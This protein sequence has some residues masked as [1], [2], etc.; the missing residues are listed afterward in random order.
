MK[1]SVLSVGYPLAPA[2]P[3]AA[4]GSEQILTLLD[5]ALV[6]EG[7]DSVV[8]A[9]EGSRVRGRLLTTPVPP[10]TL[11]EPARQSARRA[12]ARNIERA[13]ATW[14]FD[15]IHMHSLDFH[16]YLPAAATPL[17]ATLHLPPDW[18]PS[19]IFDMDRPDTW[20]QCVSRTQQENC[21]PSALLLPYI[22]NGVPID[23]LHTHVRKR[24]YALALGR[25][26]PEKGYHLALGA[27]ARAG[28]PCVLAGEIFRY[29][30]HE[31]YFWSEVL[32]R[33][34]G[35]TRRF[36]GPVGVARKRRL[37]AGARCLLVPSLVSETSSLVT[38]EA[39]ACGTPVIAFPSGALAEIVEHGRTGF[40]VRDEREMAE[41]VAAVGHI[42]PEECRRVA[43][44]RFSANRMI[45]A[46]LEMYRR[47]AGRERHA[48]EVM[49]YSS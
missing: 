42:D 9:C 21:P 16:A 34:N 7:H 15:L 25:I 47:I 41:A 11:D 2:G 39:L 33:L 5:R 30:E 12:H 4:G 19:W 10:G 26:C 29:E 6:E 38:M 48:A 20:L 45:R 46:Y 27:A 8:V 35:S 1:L 37:L 13:L 36:I 14:H 3:D 49:S 40:L 23:R 31:R 17:V 24:G 43:R 44:E 22:E 32:P 28:V 18:Y